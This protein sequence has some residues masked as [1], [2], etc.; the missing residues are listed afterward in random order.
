MLWDDVAHFD[1]QV[2]QPY[3]F[4]MSA[5]GFEQNTPGLPDRWWVKIQNWKRYR[6]PGRQPAD[7]KSHGWLRI[8]YRGPP[9]YTTAEIAKAHADWLKFAHLG[10]P[11][12]E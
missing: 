5:L 1:L 7:S 8:P 6:A 11:F 4:V 3:T 12:V 10:D 2:R 9:H